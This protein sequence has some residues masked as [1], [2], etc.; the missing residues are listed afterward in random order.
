[1]ACSAGRVE[2]PS[3]RLARI[4]E[5]YIFLAAIA[6]PSM[7]ASGSRSEPLSSAHFSAHQATGHAAA[8]GMRMRGAATPAL[9][10][11]SVRMASSG[12]SAE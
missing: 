9:R 1:M 6:T 3:S 11:A 8:S 12:W 10:A 2:N 7:V 4:D 5:K